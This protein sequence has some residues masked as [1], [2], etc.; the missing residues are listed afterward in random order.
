ME[1]VEQSPQISIPLA[2]EL[3]KR[4]RQEEEELRQKATLSA[5][6]L[7]SQLVMVE[8]EKIAD[9]ARAVGEMWQE[10]ES[11]LQ[12]ATSQQLEEGVRYN[13]PD[14][15][16]GEEPT[17]YNAMAVLAENY[18]YVIKVASLYD[19]EV[20][21]TSV[22]AEILGWKNFYAIAAGNYKN[23]RGHGLREHV[24]IC[25]PTQN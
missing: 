4:R 24:L 7:P 1:Q 21:Y 11:V 2:R 9:V 23:I 22:P 8:Q 5:A 12:S 10:L 16:D 13:I 18:G 15:L 6:G 20:P 17:F 25:V 19:D 3:L 14:D